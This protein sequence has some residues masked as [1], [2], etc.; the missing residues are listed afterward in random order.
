MKTWTAHHPCPDCDG[1]VTLE[2]E[3]GKG[4][5]EFILIHDS[6]RC[7]QGCLMTDEWLDGQWDDDINEYGDLMYE[8]QQAAR[9]YHESEGL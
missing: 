6:V 3:V 2:Y 8:R 5:D 4:R 9:Y 7:D 1:E